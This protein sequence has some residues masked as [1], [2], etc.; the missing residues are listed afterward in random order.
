MIQPDRL[1]SRAGTISAPPN[2]PT[3]WIYKPL[4]QAVSILKLWRSS[5]RAPRRWP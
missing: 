1:Q 2:P 4:P 5:L 3:D